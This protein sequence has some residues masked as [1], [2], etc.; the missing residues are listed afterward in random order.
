MS[1]NNM[2]NMPTI[3]EDGV[4]R[5]A[6]LLAAVNESSSS[7]GSPPSANA[8]QNGP[9]GPNSQNPSGSGMGGGLSS[10]QDSKIEQL[11]V[12]MLDQRDK[13]NDQLQRMQYRLEEME[14]KLRD[15]DKEKESLRR[16]L[17]LQAQHLPG[18]SLSLIWGLS[19]IHS[20]TAHSHPRARP[21]SLP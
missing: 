15:S 8:E 10:L 21:D 11:M 12:S 6:A 18:V 19:I 5:T 16:Q 14:D 2:C 17:D 7:T 1:W 4:D 3:S 13:L 9:Y 20:G